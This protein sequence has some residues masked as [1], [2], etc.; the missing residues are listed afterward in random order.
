MEM[1]RIAPIDAA[2]L[3]RIPE[4]CGEV[5]IGCSDVAGIVEAVIAASGRLRSEHVALKETVEALEQDHRQV[6]KASDE[7]QAIS[8]QA[9]MRLGEG[10][11]LIRNSLGQIGQLI[12]LVDTL[13]R[14]VTGFAAAMDQVKRSS[15][16]IGSIAETT[17]ILALNATIEAAR[18]GDAGRTFAVVANEVKKLAL[19]TRMATD[20]IASTI[21][22]LAVEA[23]QVILKIEGGAQ[24]S[25]SA[26]GSI[27][28]IE[29]TIAGV[30]HL[31]DEVDHRA[32]SIVHATGTISSHVAAV[33]KTLISFDSASVENEAQQAGAFERM[34][35]L[36]MTANT[37][38]DH[39]VRA[40][41]SPDDNAMVARATAATKQ[42]TER[43]EAALAD[44]SLG[45]EALFDQDYRP[46][47]GSFPPR[48]YTGLSD[49]AHSHWRPILDGIAAADRRIVATACTDMKG[50]LPTH[51][52]EF[53]RPPTGDAAHDTKYCR[54]GRILLD[55]IDQKAK[56]STAPF[57]M[58]V[59]RQEGDGRK[60]QVVRNIY[61]PL[62]IHGRRWGDL[63]LAYAL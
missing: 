45:R 40:G 31:V 60:Y 2:M 50:F 9:K 27:A 41:L 26:R 57:M 30:G 38:F 54:N 3:D 29:E 18:A 43:A 4:S 13:S 17:N 49:W 53:S 25:E 56:R 6:A 24:A 7:A 16:T 8:R 15:Q 52:S 22:A 47:A 34:E 23:E 62:I 35:I 48:H 59:Y 20:E 42:V 32:V 63:E 1:S 46:I 14:H 12:A 10:T 39:V 11:E 19:D 58:A 28:K 33:R 44:G 21:D 61:V 36:E 37:M 55:P 5:A 51:L